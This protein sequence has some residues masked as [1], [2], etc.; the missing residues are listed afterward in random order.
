MNWRG[1]VWCIEEGLGTYNSRND[2]AIIHYP[3][4]C[5]GMCK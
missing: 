2:P 1:K 5:G 4:V 3:S